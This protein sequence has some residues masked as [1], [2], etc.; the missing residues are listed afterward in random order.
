M[1]T[2]IT[3][4]PKRV[5]GNRRDVWGA[6]GLQRTKKS[7]LIDGFGEGF[8]EKAAF[9]LVFEGGHGLGKRFSKVRDQHG[10]NHE[11]GNTGWCQVFQQHRWVRGYCG[12]GEIRHIWMGLHQGCSEDSFNIMCVCEK[13][14]QVGR[15]FRTINCC[16]I[17]DQGRFT[18]VVEAISPCRMGLNRNRTAGG[19]EERALMRNGEVNHLNLGTDCIYI[20]I[21][22][23]I[24]TYIHIYIY[25]CEST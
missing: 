17:S 24:H 5:R 7:L 21:H 13:S 11:S 1:W 6:M 3:M 25:E 18:I 20:Y 16:G 23:Y 10:P 14:L 22:T 4:L 15:S 8:M 19:K 9:N 12:R 2:P